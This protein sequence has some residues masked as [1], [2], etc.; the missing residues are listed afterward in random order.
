[1]RT[2][3]TLISFIFAIVLS[4]CASLWWPQ[5][6][7]STFQSNKSGVQKDQKPLEMGFGDNGY[8]TGRNPTVVRGLPDD[9]SVIVMVTKRGDRLAII[10]HLPERGKPFT[11]K[12][13]TA[14]GQIEAWFLADVQSAGFLADKPLGYDE[15]VE[16]GY[17]KLMSFVRLPPD[18]RHETPTSHRMEG[19]ITFKSTDIKGNPDA[20]DDFKLDLSTI[21]PVADLSSTS[22]KKLRVKGR[23]QGCWV[24]VP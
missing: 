8:D 15:E 5:T 16:T 17:Q 18:Q 3:A 4:G 24:P 12:G 19:T 14:A 13:G 7:G 6:W 11:F 20:I 21:N 23:F 9:T 2:T 1:M 22:P 10:C